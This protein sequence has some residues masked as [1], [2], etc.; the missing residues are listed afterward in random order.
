MK[1]LRAILFALICVACLC[2]FSTMKIID[3]IP[4]RACQGCAKDRV[5]LS[6]IPTHEIFSLFS[7][8]IAIIDVK[9]QRLCS[10][11]MENISPD[12]FQFTT[13]ATMDQV[14]VFVARNMKPFFCDSEKPQNTS[15]CMTDEF[16]TPQKR[17]I[18]R[19]EQGTFQ[20]K[21]KTEV[22]KTLRTQLRI[23]HLN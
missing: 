2:L 21:A 20:K 17:H 23:F 7:Q 5:K 8:D 3:N 4:T 12:V 6:K 16:V 14:K 1:S 18:A 11:C 15:E 9:N 19:T 22:T 10:G 13:E